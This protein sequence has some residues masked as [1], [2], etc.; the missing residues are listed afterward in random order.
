M[1]NFTYYY[2]YYHYL[3]RYTFVGLVACSPFKNK[4]N[5]NFNN[6]KTDYKR[7]TTANELLEFKEFQKISKINMKLRLKL[8][9]V[10]SKTSFKKY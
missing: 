3:N 1:L 6:I 2:Y 10:A 7:Y 5:Q 4:Y 9:V 8:D